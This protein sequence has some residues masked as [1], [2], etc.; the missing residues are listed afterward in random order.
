MPSEAL[1]SSAAANCGG[2]GDYSWLGLKINFQNKIQTAKKTPPGVRA[3][4]YS[5]ALGI[6]CLNCQGIGFGTNP[7]PT[8]GLHHDYERNPTARKFN[9]Q[10][11]FRNFNSDSVYDVS[12]KCNQSKCRQIG[13]KGA[14]LRWLLSCSSAMHV[15]SLKR[16]VFVFTSCSLYNLINTRDRA[17][18]YLSYWRFRPCLDTSIYAQNDWLSEKKKN[19]QDFPFRR[20]QFARLRHNPWG[21]S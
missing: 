18:A 21:P 1:T 12:V 2:S 10:L 17:C 6:W 15:Y 20:S 8:V 16:K 11:I 7:P 13:Q 3:T 9:F 14:A 4:Q 5:A 19:N